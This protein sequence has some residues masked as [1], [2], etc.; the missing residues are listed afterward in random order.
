[1]RAR[2]SVLVVFAANGLVTASWASRVPAFREA[3]AL[4]EQSLGLVL[5]SVSGGAVIA[6]PSSGAVVD[7]IGARATVRLGCAICVVG[8]ALIGL[9]ASVPLL[10]VGML[11]TGFGSGSWDVA[12]NVDGAAVERRSGRAMMPHFH[13]AFSL[14]T[15]AGALVGALSSGLGVSTGWHLVAVAVVVLVVTQ[16]ACGGLLTASRA[17]VDEE[18]GQPTARGRAWAA[19]GEPRVLVVGLFVLCFAFA[20]GV[21]NDWLAVGLVD[22]YHISNAHAVAGFAV[23]VAAMTVGRLLGPRLLDRH[24]R[25]AVLRATAVCAAAGVVLVVFGSLPLAMGG[26]A[27]WGLGA[28]LGFPVGMS[29]AAD[30]PAHAATRVSVVASIGY[31]AFL[32]G[33]PFMG[34]LA[35]HVGVLHAL[36]SVLALLVLGACLAGAAR[37][38]H[39]APAR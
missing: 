28:S 15:V 32:A 21:A 17:E 6:L 23:F 33:P 31:A 5:L 12:M 38:H 2:W 9:A 1:V 27:L 24:G 30:D 29:A 39:P 7:R 18:P 19:W 11:L 37:E 13:A 4:S 22:G 25:V 16:S 26:A 14:G 8:L 34:F 3:F 35:Q 10:V 36:L 20:E